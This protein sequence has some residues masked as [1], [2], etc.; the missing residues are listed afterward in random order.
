MARQDFIYSQGKYEVRRYNVF[1]GKKAAAKLRGT[2]LVLTNKRVLVKT[3]NKD[4]FSQ[5]NIVE[6]MDINDVA[7]ISTSISLKRNVLMI[8]LCGI[9]AL[10]LLITGISFEDEGGMFYFIALIFAAL[11]AF[12]IVFPQVEGTVQIRKDK[13]ESGTITIF[14]GKL[15][16]NKSLFTFILNIEK[17]RHFDLMQREIGKIINDIKNGVKVEPASRNT[18]SVEIEEDIDIEEEEDD[19]PLI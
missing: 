9:F 3:Y 19:I 8:L 12:F 14:G 7:S 5:S 15:L 13:T 4:F 11:T 18:R 16:R 6:E 1:K 2:D 10:S 17:G